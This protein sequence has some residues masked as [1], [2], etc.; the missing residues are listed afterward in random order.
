MKPAQNAQSCGTQQ[1]TMEHL[2]HAF[3]PTTGD[4]PAH[5]IPGGN[6]CLV[7]CRLREG[8]TWLQFKRINT[9]PCPLRARL[10]AIFPDQPQA[11]K[12]ATSGP[13]R[14]YLALQWPD[15]FDLKHSTPPD[16]GL[17]NWSQRAIICTAAQPS[18]GTD[19]ITLRYFASQYGVVEDTDTGS[20]TKVLADYWSHRYARLTAAPCSPVGGQLLSVLSPEHV[21]I[22]GRC[23]TAHTRASN[24]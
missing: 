15:D 14:G 2:F 9:E 16:N 21:E 8:M 3:M 17:S 22:D 4:V 20:A 1:G 23:M 19:A 18:T 24:A 12:S 6:P 13:E 7:K 11:V 10:E 5:Q